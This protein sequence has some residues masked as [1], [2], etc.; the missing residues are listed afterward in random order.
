M[1]SYIKK[2]LPFLI[3][4]SKQQLIY[5]SNILITSLNNIAIC[6]TM[7]FLWTHALDGTSG[8][9]YTK[10]SIILYFVLT[11][12]G[13]LLFSINPVLKLSGAIRGGNLAQDMLKPIDYFH[14]GLF[15]HI[16]TQLHWII[17]T[18][19]L[20]LAISPQAIGIILFMACTFFM[21]YALMMLISLLAF[22]LEAMWPLQ[23]M[24]YGIFMLLGGL[25]FP[26]DILPP[27]LYHIVQYNPFAIAG[28]RFSKMLINA[29][30]LKEILF[31]A[32]LSMCY[33]LIMM[34]IF[35]S[36][37]RSLY[38]LHEGVGA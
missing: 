28:Y 8:T 17:I 20:A 14:K 10:S 22:Y 12:L 30:S 6:I 1:L 5:R 29:P 3:L 24:L 11:T 16:G 4:S 19:I 37:F 7:C 25:S 15:S 18:I 36:G 33:G 32:S 27:K 35:R 31:W 2:Y 13:S 21:F 9:G 34:I 38:R 23:P 26:L